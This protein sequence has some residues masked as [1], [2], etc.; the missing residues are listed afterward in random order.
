MVPDAVT[1]L[2]FN[3]GLATDYL[4]GVRPELAVLVNV[5]RGRFKGDELAE[6]VHLALMCPTG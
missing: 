4:G 6:R 3:L 2:R 5:F 1:G